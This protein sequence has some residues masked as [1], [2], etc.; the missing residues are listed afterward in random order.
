[1]NIKFIKKNKESNIMN[2]KIE[3]SAVKCESYTVELLE[4]KVKTAIEKAGGWPEKIANAKSVLLKPNLLTARAPEQAVTTHPEVVRAVIREL[5]R[6][7]VKNISLGDSPAGSYSWDKLWSTTGMKQVCEEENVTLLPFENV[8]R[9]ECKDG[10]SLPVLK[11][12]DD[13]DAVI[14][15]PKLKTHILTKLTGAVKNSY[16]LIPGKAKSMFHG[17][18]QSPRQ[19]GLFIAD[20]FE[21]IK[22]DFVIMDGVVCMQGEGPANGSPFPLGAIFAG[23]DA[24]ALDASVCEVYNYKA[25]DIPNLVKVAENGS[26]IIDPDKIQRTGDAWDIVASKKPKKSHSDFLHKIPEKMFHVLTLFL[27]YRP[28]ISQKSCVK[29]GI[30]AKVCSQNAIEKRADGSYHVKGSKCIL[31]MCCMESCAEHAI[32]L[33]SPVK[34]LFR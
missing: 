12:L 2:K 23:E 5:R 17:D 1:L 27:S 6:T 31:C 22:P 28:H 34:R 16:G 18:Y 14:S 19:M 10:T 15:L 3:I 33:A 8:K 30:C 26:G 29:C 21:H 9:I 20:I 24:A 7:G 32:E 25:S 13:F 11:E 4:E